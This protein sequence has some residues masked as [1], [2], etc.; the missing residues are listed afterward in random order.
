MGVTHIFGISVDTFFIY[1][2]IGL[3]FVIGWIVLILK[4][5]K[6]EKG[7]ADFYFYNKP[8][9]KDINEEISEWEHRLITNPAYDI[10]PCNTFHDDHENL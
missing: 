8:F 1:W 4:I 10:L 2:L 7:E 6:N 9:S 5:N 3:A